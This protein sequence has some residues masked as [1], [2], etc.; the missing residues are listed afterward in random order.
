MEQPASPSSV[1]RLGGLR[2]VDFLR[3]EQF[4]IENFQRSELNGGADACEYG[5][6]PSVASDGTNRDNPNLWVTGNASFQAGVL[7]R[8]AWV[9][10]SDVPRWLLPFK[11]TLYVTTF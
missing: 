1:F 4:H 5:T 3:R 2:V 8:A 11:W 10:P 9:G 6:H 7:N